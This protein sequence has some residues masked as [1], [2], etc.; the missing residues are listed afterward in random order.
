VRNFEEGVTAWKRNVLTTWP[1]VLRQ[2]HEYFSMKNN[3]WPYAA[4]V[5]FEHLGMPFCSGLDNIHEIFYL[6]GSNRNQSKVPGLDWEMLVFSGLTG[7]I[8]NSRDQHEVNKAASWYKY[9]HIQ[10][11][12]S[13]NRKHLLTFRTN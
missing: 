2:F 4:F 1:Y 3:T 10:T 8:Y 13:R 11:L 6:W 7:N 12:L 5:V 9:R